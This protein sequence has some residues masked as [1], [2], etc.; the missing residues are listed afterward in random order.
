MGSR[1][2]SRSSWPLS[3]ARQGSGYAHRSPTARE[4]VKVTTEDDRNSELAAAGQYPLAIWQLTVYWEL[5]SSRSARS[6]SV[7]VTT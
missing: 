3:Q 7:D 2:R 1:R 4:A 6:K 5:Y